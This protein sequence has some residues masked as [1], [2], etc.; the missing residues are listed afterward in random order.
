MVKENSNNLENIIGEDNFANYI[1]N[2][3]DLIDENYYVNTDFENKEYNKFYSESIENKL[4]NIQNSNKI[5]QY[6]NMR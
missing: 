2:Q 4:N 6:K 5:E 3:D 1:N